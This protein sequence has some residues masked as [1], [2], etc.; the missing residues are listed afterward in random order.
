MAVAMFYEV[1]PAEDR[2]NIDFEVS[3]IPDSV[4]DA[5]LLRKVWGNLL[6]NAVTF[7]RSKTPRR[8][9]VHARE[10]G[11][12][13]RYEV[14]DNGIGFDQAYEDKLFKLFGHLH[15]AE[16]TDGPGAGLAIVRRII[17]RHLGHVGAEGR[18]GEGA[19]FWFSLPHQSPI[20][21]GL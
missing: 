20:N 2:E 1:T 7:S 17:E 12:V 5:F 18:V 10:D 4:G 15:G 21:L 6:R 19:T 8:I 13:T 16:E 3:D 14:S 9:R 11:A